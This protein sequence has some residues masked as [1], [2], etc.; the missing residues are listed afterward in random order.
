MWTHS[1]SAAAAGNT[2]HVKTM[3]TSTQE[4]ANPAALDAQSGSIHSGPMMQA[5]Q[6]EREKEKP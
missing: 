4:R 6:A 5:E 3:C 2:T 1:D